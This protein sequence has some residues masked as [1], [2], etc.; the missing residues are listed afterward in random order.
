MASSGAKYKDVR[1]IGGRPGKW[2][3]LIEL[4]AERR[5]K[6]PKTHREKSGETFQGL[7]K[8]AI[9]SS[10]LIA[11]ATMLLMPRKDHTHDPHN[12]HNHPW[13]MHYYLQ[14]SSRGG[15]GQNAD[16]KGLRSDR[17]GENAV[18]LWDKFGIKRD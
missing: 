1:N 2:R 6:E 15:W 14:N 5:R 13:S 9:G 18:C 8:F 11:K 17:V 10:L 12:P 7:L 3:Q 16:H 4:K